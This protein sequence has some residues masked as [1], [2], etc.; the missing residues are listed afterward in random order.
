MLYYLV[1]TIKAVAR[2]VIQH[3]Q[4]S[5]EGFQDSLETAS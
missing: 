3:I 5:E 2:R 4:I 1:S